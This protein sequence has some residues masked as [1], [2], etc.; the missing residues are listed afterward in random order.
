MWKQN[1]RARQLHSLQ[2]L[3]PRRA[4]IEQLSRGRCTG[5][6]GRA[7]GLRVSYFASGNEEDGRSRLS[8]SF[9]ARSF[10]MRSLT[11]RKHSEC[12]SFLSIAGPTWPLRWRSKE[13]GSVHLKAHNFHSFWGTAMCRLGLSFEHWG[14]K[15]SVRLTK[16]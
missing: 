6:R 15:I 7:N 5:W 9:C 14:D 2:G 3:L 1:R 4:G 10:S 11:P 12:G 13:D 8:T 16:A